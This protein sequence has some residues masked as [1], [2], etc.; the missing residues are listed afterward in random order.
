MALD[1][2]ENPD[3]KVTNIADARKG[4]L[5]KSSIA[6]GRR[7]GDDPV[8]P[9]KCARLEIDQN[10]P[11]VRVVKSSRATGRRFDRVKVDKIKAQLERGEYQIDSLRVAD[12]FIEHERHS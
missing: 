9:N 11:N 6:Y 10:K 12:H 5:D 2:G 4:R 7:H 8:G 3:S 1:K